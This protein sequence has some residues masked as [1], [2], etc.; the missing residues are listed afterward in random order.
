MMMVAR[1]ELLEDFLQNFLETEKDGN[2]VA[3]YMVQLVR[4]ACCS[5]VVV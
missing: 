3:K 5:L 1:V 4:G 2:T